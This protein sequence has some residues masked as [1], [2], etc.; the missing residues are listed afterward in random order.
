MHNK[1]LNEAKRFVK[2]PLKA[3]EKAK[4]GRQ[5]YSRSSWLSYTKSFC[6]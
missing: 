1:D 6:R 4:K 3:K 2:K 5:H